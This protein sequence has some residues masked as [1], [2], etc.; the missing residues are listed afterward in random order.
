[1]TGWSF[2]RNLLGEIELL[3]EWQTDHPGQ[4]EFLLCKIIPCRDK[5]LAPALKF[6]L[7]PQHVNIGRDA[8]RFHVLSLVVQGLRGLHFSIG[9]IDPCAGG[10]ALKISGPHC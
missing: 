5:L 1:M 7:G 9:R 8:H 3:S 6:H 4:R 10:G 2:V